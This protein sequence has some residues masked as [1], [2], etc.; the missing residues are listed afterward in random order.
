MARPTGARG[1][2]GAGPPPEDPRDAEIV[3]PS[4]PEGAGGP[5][6]PY[7]APDLRGLAEEV[8][9]LVS[10]LNNA[11]RHSLEKDIPVL[12]DSLTRF[13]QRKP[14]V[15][16]AGTRVVLAGNGTLEA[17]RALGW[18]H[19]AVSW[20]H[21]TEEEA[22]EYALVDNRSAELSTWDLQELATQLSAVR[23]RSGPEALTRLGWADHESAPLLASTWNAPAEGRLHPDLPARESSWRS[24]SL[25]VGQ[26][27]VVEL[28][29]QRLQQLEHD[30]T[31]PEGRALELICADYLAGRPADPVD[32]THGG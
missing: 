21:G 9:T 16:M 30:G 6:L 29:I 15:A 31:I 24:V 18:S 10:A 28:A 23:A 25:S 27:T 8:S 17:A 19:L 22:Q 11:R 26:F 4:A 2:R 13:G 3:A 32:P 1:R 14:I 20:F 7:L 5:D 12:M